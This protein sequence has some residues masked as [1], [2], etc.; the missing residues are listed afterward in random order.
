M[1]SILAPIFA[2]RLTCFPEEGMV[3]FLTRLALVFKPTGCG[4]KMMLETLRP[5]LSVQTKVCAD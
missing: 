2:P 5:L 3:L 4:L 1:P